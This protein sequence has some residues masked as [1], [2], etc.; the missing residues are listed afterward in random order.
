MAGRE[1]AA[2]N[3]TA[4]ND[5]VITDV[6]NPA[7]P[8]DTIDKVEPATPETTAADGVNAFA[9]RDAFLDTL[10]VTPKGEQP[11]GDQQRDT[12]GKFTAKPG[13]TAANPAK[14]AGTAA[15]DPN[16]AVKP[17]ATPAAKTD[18]PKTAAQEADEII[19]ETGIKSERSQNRVREIVSR[20]HEL[21]GKAQQL[22]TDITEFR[23]LVQSSGLHPEE[24]VGMLETGRLMKSGNE[25]DKRLA[26]DRISA[27]RE[28]LAKELGIEAPGV[29]ALADFPDLK[30]QVENMEITPQA[31]LQ[32]AKYKRQE[33][34]QQQQQQVRQ[35]S[36]QE[37]DGF[38]QSIQQA[39]DTATQYF[40]TRKHEADYEPKMKQIHAKFKDPAFIQEFV[41]SYEPKQWF[42]IFKMMYD[43]IVIPSQSRN[44]NAQ[45]AR[46]RPTN[47]GMP[48]AAGDD[49]QVNMQNTLQQ[50]GIL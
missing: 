10:L 12:Q 29:D 34:Q 15:A 37:M 49:N 21:Q 44:N 43:S 18:T 1:E 47:L 11:A 14:P 16:A 25:A 22:E 50:M 40:D 26:F 35:Q 8:Q 23:T 48:A 31:A 32:L 46:V 38:K 7:G 6:N 28:Q 36:Q 41:S 33:I 17:G 5:P 4:G 30:K 39:S 9:E 3:N 24:F 2:D 13:E 45:P 20:S 42:G 19:K 27:Q